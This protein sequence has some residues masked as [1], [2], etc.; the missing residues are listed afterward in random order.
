MKEEPDVICFGSP[1]V[2]LE[3]VDK[4]IEILHDLKKVYGYAIFAL[5]MI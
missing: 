4:R 1:S 2:K 3:T 5:D